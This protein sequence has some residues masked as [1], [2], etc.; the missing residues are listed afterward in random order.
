MRIQPLGEILDLFHTP[1]RDAYA[2]IGGNG[3]RETWALHSKEFRELL[4]YQYYK[5]TGAIPSP[6][7]ITNDLRALAG[8]A[9]FDGAE[10][11][12]HLRIAELDD[13]IYL[14]LANDR[15]EVVEITAAG[16]RVLEDPPVKFR[17]T[18]SMRPLPQPV[19]GGSLEELRPFVN[20]G[21][22]EDWRLLVS[23]LVGTFHPWG[24]Y[25]V[26][27]L[28]GP[29]GAA[30]S[31]LM[32][33]VRALIDPNHAPIRTLPESERDLFISVERG[34]LHPYDNLSVLPI[35]ASDALCR[36]RHGRGVCHAQTLF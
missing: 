35:W 18:S 1:Q 9:R 4:E 36:P 13:R 6:K 8:K 25:P 14:D 5:T 10:L 32:R 33:V 23:F 15:W 12:V 20:V 22:E 29:H 24:P 27:V 17:R 16:W 31:T 21:A 34:W 11:P 28:R 26:L 3:H 19:R 30:K 2:T 7:T